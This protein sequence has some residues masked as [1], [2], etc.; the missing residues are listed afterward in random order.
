MTVA[1]Q[2][3]NHALNARL[4]RVDL[5]DRSKFLLINRDPRWVT[6]VMNGP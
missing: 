6:A 5:S 3:D 2:L 4:R 1:G